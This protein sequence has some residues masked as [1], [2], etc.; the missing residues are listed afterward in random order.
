[1]TVVGRHADPA[2]FA[3][4]HVDISSDAYGKHDAF[5][6]LDM[7]YGLDAKAFDILNYGVEFG[8]A[9]PVQAQVF[10]TYTEDYRIVLL[11]SI[12]VMR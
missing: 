6:C 2:R 9:V 3:E 8:I 10:W 4:I 11:G 1:M 12:T 5:A 7:H